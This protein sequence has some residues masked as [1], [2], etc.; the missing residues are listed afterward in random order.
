MSF[1]AIT[2]GYNQYS[3]FNTNV[4]TYPLL[5]NVVTTCLDEI[6]NL[7]N[8]KLPIWEEQIN[9]YNNEEEQIKKNMKKLET[10]KLSSEEK[11]IENIKSKESGIINN[12]DNINN[13][14][15]KKIDSAKNSKNANSKFEK[16]KNYY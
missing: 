1:I 13:K 3:I 10:D 5:D 16:I 4:S 6:L 2:Y 12:N 11:T 8:S 15:T 9:N 7:L 14:N